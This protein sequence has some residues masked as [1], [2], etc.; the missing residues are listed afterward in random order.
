MLAF[1]V[2][3][4]GR[5]GHF[6]YAFSL[7]PSSSTNVCRVGA[8]SEPALVVGSR[9][10]LEPETCLCPWQFPR[11]CPQ[12]YSCL[13]PT[14]FV[15]L[16]MSP[17]LDWKLHEIRDLTGLGCPVSLAQNLAQSGGAYKQR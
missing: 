4:T 17:Q 1:A 14:V 8:N 12:P 7:M 3:I 9:G 16:L 15:H 10:I 11:Q 2:D 13:H 6:P 5:A